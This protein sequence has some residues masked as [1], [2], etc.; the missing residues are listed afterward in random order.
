MTVLL[1]I[2]FKNLLFQYVKIIPK[3]R[4]PILNYTSFNNHNI[5]IRRLVKIKHDEMK[6]MEYLLIIKN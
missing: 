6:L 1:N 5:N 3:K 2:Y 4:T